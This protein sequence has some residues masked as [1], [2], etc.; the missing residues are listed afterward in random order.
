MRKLTF[1]GFLKQYVV[2][3]SG[4]QTAS[5]HKLADCM[6]EN[7]RLKEPLYLYALAFDKVDLLLRYTVNRAV[8]AEY[9]QLSKVHPCGGG[10]R[11]RR[12]AAVG[13]RLR[14]GR[15]RRAGWH[16]PA[17]KRGVPHP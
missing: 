1:E 9:E 8:A 3:L 6:T 14:L 2:E 12:R 17:D 11:H 5:V 16:L 10:G 7:P 15:L 13:G 4:V